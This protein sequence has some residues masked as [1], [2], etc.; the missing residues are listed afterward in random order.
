MKKT[1]IALIVLGLLLSACSTGGADTVPD[2]QH[3]SLVPV[4]SSEKAEKSSAQEETLKPTETQKGHDEPT[5]SEPV[6][7][8]S[9][10]PTLKKQIRTE[11][12]V[13]ERPDPVSLFAS[14]RKLSE[15]EITGWELFFEEDNGLAGHF[16]CSEYMK[17][18]DIDLGLAFYDGIFTLK[19]DGSWAGETVSEAEKSA[20]G[21]PEG[22][23]IKKI[24]REAVREKV[25][26]YTGLELEET[27]QLHL[28]RYTFL[29]AYDAYYLFASDTVRRRYSVLEGVEKEDGTVWLHW[30]VSSEWETR[31]NEGL[32]SLQKKG[33][34]WVFRS[35]E[36]IN[37]AKTEAL[38][39]RFLCIVKKE[40]TKDQIDSLIA[41]IDGSTN[42]LN[43]Y[44]SF[45]GAW[46]SIPSETDTED[47]TLIKWERGMDL[48]EQYRFSEIDGYS[49]VQEEIDQTL[50]DGTSRIMKIIYLICFQ[51]EQ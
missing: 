33:E 20:L 37:A 12:I 51:Q 23:E 3:S 6:P 48:E 15:T 7:E 31:D 41:E 47:Y 32:V 24:R 46:S 28:D 19:D 11:I 2:T 38:L 9:P 13:K 1:L 17:A 30:K 43:S 45:G 22:I 35:N 42:E 27:V 21:N 4:S 10:V 40:M 5:V 39:P 26:Q 8:S 18:A 50:K 44:V 36:L 34:R 25:R 49:R 14:G 29:E 16:L